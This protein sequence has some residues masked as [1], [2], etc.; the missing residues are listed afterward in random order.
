[1]NKRL[2]VNADDFGLCKGVNR[3]IQRAHTEG[4]L[5]SATIMAGA[6]ATD[7]ALKIASQMPSLGVGIHLNLV[8]GPASCQDGRAN[9]LINSEGELKFSPG[10]VALMSMICPKT[11]RA[12]KAEL[13]AQIQC[14]LEKGLKPTHFD[15][16]KH[17]H[18]FPSIYP[19]VVKLA[20]QFGI[21]AIR[22]PSENSVTRSSNWPLPSKSGK[23]NAQIITTMAR[24]NRCQ[25]KSLIKNDSFYGIAHTGKADDDFWQAV[26]SSAKEEV[27]EVMTHPGYTDGLDPAKTRLIEQRQIELESLCSEKRKC[28][29]AEAKIELI[30]YGN[31]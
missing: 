28:A 26:C 24:I 23:T 12:I 17:V 25:D 9:M 10:K 5:T 4:I 29:V 1:M 30:H 20:H 16:H 22:W 7:E 15:S 2:I 3:A 21:K 11:R 18:T 6:D 13:T 27:A 8:E 31:L 19:I 14:L